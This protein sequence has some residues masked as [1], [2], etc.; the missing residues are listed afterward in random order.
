MQC[1]YAENWA[2]RISSHFYIA[3]N[4]VPKVEIINGKIDV[5]KNKK[6]YARINAKHRFEI[7]YAEINQT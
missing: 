2:I 6:S 7:T 5:L 1:L 3:K 4:F